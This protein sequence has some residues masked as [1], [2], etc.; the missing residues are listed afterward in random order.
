MLIDIPAMKAAA[1]NR[2]K[3]P[4]K[5]IEVPAADISDTHFCCK[6]SKNNRFHI[7]QLVNETVMKEIEKKREK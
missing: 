6:P 2:V 1:K 3:K 4:F 5:S 7:S